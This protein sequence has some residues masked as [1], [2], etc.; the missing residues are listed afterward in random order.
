MLQQLAD[1]A[2]QFNISLSPEQLQQFER[3]SRELLAWNSRVNLTRIVDPQEIVTKHFLDS[4]SV[5]VALPALSNGAT[6]IDV[7]SGAGFPGVPLN[8]AQPDLR[9]TLLEATGKKTKFLHHLVQMLTLPNVTVLTARAEE[10]G[11]V[12]QH[13]ERYDVAV[14]R[15]VA[16]LPVLAEY[17]LPL[18]KIGGYAV[19]QKG[20]HPATEL[21][22][23]TAAL[24]I[25]G[26]TLSQLSAVEVP[27]LDAPRHLITL[28][29]IKPTPKQYPRRA[30][31]PAKTPL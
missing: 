2:R 15:A 30:G 17:L 10:V 22:A 28:A 4:L 31:V 29:K 27:G 24:R 7:G 3:Y 21:T 18:I 6:I 1:G 23:A 14:A 5:L 11:L 20:Q 13:R 19:V 8:I 9:L 16:P 26:G 12:A 25:L